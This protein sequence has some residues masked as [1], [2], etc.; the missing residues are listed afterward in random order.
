LSGNSINVEDCYGFLLKDGK[1]AAIVLEVENSPQAEE[2]MK[3]AGFN[4]LE[5]NKLYN[6]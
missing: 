1:S 5:E 4:V 6:C 3:L 2:T